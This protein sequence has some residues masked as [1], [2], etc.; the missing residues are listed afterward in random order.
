MRRRFNVSRVLVL[1]TPPA[2]SKPRGGGRCAPCVST[3]TSLARVG[4]S[5]VTQGQ[6]RFRV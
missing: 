6:T 3:D 2:C 1:N 5:A 4:S